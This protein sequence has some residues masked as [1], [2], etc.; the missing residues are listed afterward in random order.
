MGLRH[1][2]RRS[3]DLDGDRP[4]HPDRKLQSLNDWYG[5]GFIDAI[6]GEDRTTNGW[7]Y[8]GRLACSDQ[9]WMG[10]KHARAMEIDEDGKVV[11]VITGIEE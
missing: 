3:K 10:R 7:Q 5:F 6:I 9:Y 1:P 2:H 11:G 4:P 8:C